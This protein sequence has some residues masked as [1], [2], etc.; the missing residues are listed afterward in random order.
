VLESSVN[1]GG[2]LIS[3]YQINK[4]GTRY[5][6]GAKVPAEILEDQGSNPAGGNGVCFLLSKNAQETNQTSFSTWDRV[7]LNNGNR[8]VKLTIRLRPLPWSRIVGALILEEDLHMLGE[9]ST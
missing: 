6:S 4:T 3:V 9:W 8:G 5:T 2:L 7:A 1:F